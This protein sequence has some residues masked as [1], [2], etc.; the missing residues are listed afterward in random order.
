MLCTNEDAWVS[1]VGV[2]ATVE[3]AE[4]AMDVDRKNTSESL[5]QEG[6]VVSTGRD[7]DG[8]IIKYGNGHF[9]RYTI[10]AEEVRK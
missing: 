7:E 2:Y 10:K 8:A 4:V 1:I 3:R 9:Y 5:E 6:Y